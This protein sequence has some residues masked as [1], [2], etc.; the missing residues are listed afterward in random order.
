MTPTYGL[1]TNITV[2][3]GLILFLAMAL[4]AFVSINLVERILSMEKT[5]K[6]RMFIT[7]LEQT[8]AGALSSREGKGP[9]QEFPPSVTRIM[10]EAGISAA[11]I[12]YPGK[13]EFSKLGEPSPYELPLR[14]MAR[15][16]SVSGNPVEKTTGF[17]FGLFWTQH[18][19]I[20]YAAPMKTGNGER[21][22]IGLHIPLSP[23]YH[24]IRKAQSL[25]FLY[26]LINCVL[27][28]WAGVH[29]IGKVAVKPLQ[30]LLRRA[31]AFKG[32][33]GD[34]AFDEKTGNEFSKLSTALN[35][36]LGRIS[37]HKDE[38][39]KTVRSLER[40]NSELKKAQSDII[41]AEK[42]A[43]VGRL[44]SGIA[45][46]IGNPLGI[47]S[48]YLELLKNQAIPMTQK[49]D[50]IERAEKELG[51]IDRI[52][53]QLLN[54]A[55][56][57]PTSFTDISVHDAI[58]D[59]AEMMRFQPLMSGIA[60]DLDLSAELDRINGDSDQ[61]R[62]ILLNLAINAR[63]AIVASGGEHKG[64]LCIETSVL[65]ADEENRKVKNLRVIVR[66]NGV[67][68]PKGNLGNIF[69]PF[70]TTKEPGKG[71]G[72]G[73]SVCYTMVRDMGGTIEVSSEEGQ[74]TEV[75]LVFPVT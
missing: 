49:L 2:N 36:M 57:K 72:L 9:W 66:D 27:M 41:R 30:R 7:V 12:V 22:G 23:M 13:R 60:F 15:E 70:F 21:L 26:I 68:I 64:T 19:S 6:G 24:Q 39:E 37:T 56:T 8:C 40:A 18:Q 54:Y 43:S 51:R 10:N 71:T 67:G 63:D 52:I 50:F 16:S 14:F 35:N 20:L 33:T 46:E 28:T 59:V 44:S 47:V 3:V 69:D 5:D 11:V 1:K 48:G 75:L 61:L 45:H 65:I 29:Q 53:K 17:G 38:L 73:L 42:L 31:E 74:G 62:Q 25:I 58:R 34:F 4:T 32:E 55:R